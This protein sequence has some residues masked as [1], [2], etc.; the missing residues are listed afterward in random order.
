MFNDTFIETH[1][2]YCFENNGTEVLLVCF[3]PE[4]EVRKDHE[5]KSPVAVKK[6]YPFREFDSRT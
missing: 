2:T 4:S 5:E 6:F 1:D 3:E